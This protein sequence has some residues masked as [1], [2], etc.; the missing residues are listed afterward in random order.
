[1]WLRLGFQRGSITGNELGHL[2]GKGF[3]SLDHRQVFF[4]RRNDDLFTIAINT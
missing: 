4:C 3:I 1:M 2:F